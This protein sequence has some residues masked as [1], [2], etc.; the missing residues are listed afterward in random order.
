VNIKDRFY[1]S[2]AEQTTIDQ[3]VMEKEVEKLQMELDSLR[4]LFSVWGDRLDT[5]HIDNGELTIQ[6][7][8]DFEMF[9]RRAA[10]C[11]TRVMYM[12]GA[13]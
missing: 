9:A 7:L 8:R 3:Q 11:A 5:K 13:E 4:V 12:K 1:H 10:E 2:L 6:T